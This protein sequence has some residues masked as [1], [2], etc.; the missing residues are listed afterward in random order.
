MPHR[1]PNSVII[2]LRSVWKI[3]RMGSVSVEALRGLTL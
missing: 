1:T 2:E 3:Y